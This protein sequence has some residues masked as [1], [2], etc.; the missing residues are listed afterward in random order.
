[1]KFK[2]LEI[3]NKRLTERNRKKDFVRTREIFELEKQ[4]TL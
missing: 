2:V 4:T 1:M 3:Y